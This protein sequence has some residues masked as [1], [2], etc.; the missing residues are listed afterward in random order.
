MQSKIPKADFSF[1]QFSINQDKCAMKVGVE[2][3][4]FGAWCS[5]NSVSEALDIGS[6][7]GILSLML[8][9]RNSE[10]TV[11]GLE[12]DEHACAQA[13]ENFENSPFKERLSCI[14]GDFL[15]HGLTREFD[16]II[17]NPPFF[18]EGI[19]SSSGKRNLARFEDNLPLSKLV[20]GI[21]SLLKPKGKCCFLLPIDRELELIDTAI[22]SG[23][24][25]ERITKI[26][27]TTKKPVSR[28]FVQFGLN[29]IKKCVN[30]NLLIYADDNTY[31][32]EF[33]KLTKNF[34]LN[35]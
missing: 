4:A 20:S 33:K 10:L 27:S 6:G 2:A 18:K 9:Q 34:Y 16:L 23:L 24:Y 30:E 8:A 21:S 26:Q 13:N 3:V 22:K 1:K 29:A 19:R 15:N 11:L 14:H 12:I 28:V 32:A 31:T 7:T 35:I 25:T 5:V 17:S